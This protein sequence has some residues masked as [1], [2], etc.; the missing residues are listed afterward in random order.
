MEISRVMYL[1]R[2]MLCKGKKLIFYE[3]NNV[4]FLIKISIDLD[5]IGKFLVKIKV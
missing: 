1:N 5:D 4:I 3:N 2:L